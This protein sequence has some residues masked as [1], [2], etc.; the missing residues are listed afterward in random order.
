MRDNGRRTACGIALTGRWVA[1]TARGI[2]WTARGIASTACGIAWIA[3]ATATL[4][5]GGGGGGAANVNDGSG[6]RTQSVPPSILSEGAA[7][8]QPA[9]GEL[10]LAEVGF[11]FGSPDAPIKVLEFSDFACGYC[12]R[13]HA[14]TFPALLEE[15]IETGRVEWKYVTF[16][17]GLFPN[18]GATALASECVGEQGLFA[19]MSELLYARQSEWKSLSSPAAAL[20]A[21]AVE[22]G[23]DAADYRECVAEERP[24]ARIRSGV[25]TGA[26]L[27]VRGT[28][29][30]LINGVPLVGARPL[31][32]WA[33][34]FTVIEA[35]AAAGRGGA[36]PD[37]SS[38][39]R[40]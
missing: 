29:T 12:R 5:C 31:G 17:S 3:L 16:V 2:A 22:A 35:E 34:I 32:L 13:F 7:G 4:A 19:E 14:E 23:A 18:G 27:G 20:E 36:E 39:A 21:L 37:S 6:S 40:P 24:L 33:D 30:F 11:N 15:Y 38:G 9:P 10:P 1:R 28:P 26:R 8:V 25:L